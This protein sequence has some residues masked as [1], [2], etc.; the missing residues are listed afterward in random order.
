MLKFL[1]AI[2]ITSDASILSSVSFGCYNR[3]FYG[4]S[5]KGL[6]PLHS[7]NITTTRTT[8]TAT[9][10]EQLDVLCRIWKIYFVG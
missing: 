5:V 9:F 2:L 10:Y 6:G 8:T 3:Q 4:L 7:K 1:L